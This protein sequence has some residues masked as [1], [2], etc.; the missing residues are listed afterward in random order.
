MNRRNYARELERIIQKRG[1]T[2]PRVL[3]HSCCGPC[4]SSVL[5]YL[6][7]YFDVTLLWYN[8]NIYPDEEFERR[9]KAQLEMIEK[10]GLAGKV[11]VLAEPRRNK[12]YESMIKGLENEPEGGKRCAECFR[13]RLH[14]AA[15]FCKQY[16]YDYF[17]TTLT[18][19]RHKDSV[20]INSIGEEIAAEYGVK[21]LPSDFK[22][23]DGE[24]RSV[25]L[26][27]K[28]GIYRQIY[29]GCRYSLAAREKGKPQ[30][31]N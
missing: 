26:S 15:K 5:E 16:G 1:S 7:Q 13:L 17:T 3:L 11:T 29:C 14:E 19:S 31:E 22:K 8:P 25:E 6:T 20:L 4:S 12:D 28:Y 18:V 9:Y 2:A 10:M 21:W 23:R 24:N 30:P 27:E